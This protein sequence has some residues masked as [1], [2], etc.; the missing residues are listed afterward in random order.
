M[1]H[2]VD[3]VLAAHPLPPT[4]TG[5]VFTLNPLQREDV[6]L[7]IP[8]ERAGMF[9]PVGYGKTVIATLV[10]LAHQRPH[11]IVLLPPILVDQWVKW[12]NSVGNSG[13]AVAYNDKS[14]KKRKALDLR[15]YRWWVMSYGLY[16]N[17]ED[18]LMRVLGDAPFSLVVDEAQNLK[19]HNSKLFLC[20]QRAVELKGAH[21]LLP[22]GTELNNPG[23][24]Y[25]YIKLKTPMIY[26]TKAHFENV[27]VVERDFFERPTLWQGEDVINH[28]LYLQSA[29]RTKEEVHA[30]LPKANYIPMEYVLEPGHLKLYTEMAEK[31]LLETMDGGKIDGST[32]QKLR[33]ALQQIVINWGDFAGDPELRW[34]SSFYS[35]LD[36]VMDEIDVQHLKASKL[37]VWTWFRM[38]TRNITDYL[39]HIGVPAVAAYSEVDSV[40]SVAAFMNDPEIRAGVFQPGSAGAGLN[41][42]YFCWES[43]FAEV[44]TRS[45]PFRQ[46]AGRIDREGQ[47]FNPNIRIAMAKG[48]VQGGMYSDLLRND[49]QVQQVQG[50]IYDLRRLVY[51]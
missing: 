45:I 46:S 47:R 18:H 12:L 40:K 24:A 19:N 25:A 17:D 33:N 15:A 50:N 43:I 10:V 48:T 23:D 5:D 3:E 44:P 35:L 14:P 16:R 20:V 2:N 34:A 32:P 7:L 38:T 13:G 21:L 4:P 6:N 9:L 31:M 49:G 29:H 30:H 22:T 37:I 51:G 39:N 26:R 27:H 11:C 1:L 36:T 8:Y 41:P 42:Q 28:N